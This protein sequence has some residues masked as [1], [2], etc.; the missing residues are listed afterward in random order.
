VELACLA[1]LQQLDGVLVYMPV[2]SVSKGFTVQHA[3]RCMVP[4]LS[5][6]D[7]R[8]QLAALLPSNAPE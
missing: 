1:G 3:G 6:M 5:S 4:T 7:L 8:E 2:K